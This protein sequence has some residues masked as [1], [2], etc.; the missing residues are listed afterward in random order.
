MKNLLKFLTISLLIILTAFPLFACKKQSEQNF[1]GTYKSCFI[2]QQ[3]AGNK[4][5]FTLIIKEDNTFS[6][7]RTD[8]SKL[9]K[10]SWTTAT[11]DNTKQVLC[12]SNTH[13]NNYYPYFSLTM[14]DDGK[15][16]ASA[17][18]N[19][20]DFAFGWASHPISLIIFEKLL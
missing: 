10:G 2:D 18:T 5:S 16:I 20:Y 4:A 14:T 12:Y 13:E 1:A 7:L 8:T 11:L 19:G 17:G 3:T 15:L 9:T 6:L